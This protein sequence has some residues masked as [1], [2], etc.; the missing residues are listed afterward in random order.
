[1]QPGKM[2]KVCIFVELLLQCPYNFGLCYYQ[3]LYQAF[4]S[5]W[6]PPGATLPRCRQRQ[7]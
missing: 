7:G 6:R 5:A 3:A 1:M 4:E 2:P